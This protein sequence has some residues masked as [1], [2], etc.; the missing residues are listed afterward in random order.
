FLQINFVSL[1][2]LQVFVVVPY[3]NVHQHEI[4]MEQRSDAG[5]LEGPLEYVTVDAPVAAEVEQ[6]ALMLAHRRDQRLVDLGACIRVFPIQRRIGLGGNLER[7]LLP[8][9]QGD[10]CDTKHRQQTQ[11]S[12]WCSHL[13]DFS[14]FF[15][16][17]IYEPR[18]F[19]SMVSLTIHHDKME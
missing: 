17:R 2:Q 16:A 12:G 6:Y 7:R 8:L 15:A 13:S 4:V 19:G 3:I 10:D 5:L 18:N 1:R 14:G 11:G 9:S